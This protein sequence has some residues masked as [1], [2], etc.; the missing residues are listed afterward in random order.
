[1]RI[2]QSRV[3]RDLIDA[4]QKAIEAKN[5]MQ[6]QTKLTEVKTTRKEHKAK[7]EKLEQEL[8]ELLTLNQEAQLT[9]SGVVN[10]DGTGGF[11]GGSR[12]QGQQRPGQGQQ[13][14]GSGQQ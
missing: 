3:M 6:I 8:I 5:D 14:S 10:S 1:M 11:F 12:G 4:L 2:N 7:V 9:V 13:R